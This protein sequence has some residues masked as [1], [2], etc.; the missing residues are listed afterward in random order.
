MMSV[1]SDSTAGSI[2]PEPLWLQILSVDDRKL[3]RDE[4]LAA[5]SPER[6]QLAR[7]WHRTAAVHAD[8][9]LARRLS[10]PLTI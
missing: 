3:F 6:E 2:A 10:N 4:W 5:P 1:T 9:K 8:R 7:E